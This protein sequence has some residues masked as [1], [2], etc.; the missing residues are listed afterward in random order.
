MDKS[1]HS[2][3][4]NIFFV[5][6]TDIRSGGG[7]YLKVG[8]AQSAGNCFTVPQWVATSYTRVGTLIYRPLLSPYMHLLYIYIQW[9]IQMSSM[10][11]I[12]E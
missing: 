7:T 3:R 9:L 2:Y 10:I 4:D 5:I 12:K 8:G 1:R 11:D 6:V